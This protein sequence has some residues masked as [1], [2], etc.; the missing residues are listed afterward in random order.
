MKGFYYTIVFL[1]NFLLNAYTYIII[2]RAIVSWL[3]PNPY[4]PIIRLLYRVTEPVLG[5]VRRLLPDLGGLDLSP[6][7]V[8]LAIMLIKQLL[9]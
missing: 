6:V 2:A 4:N 9:I 8:I 1:L 7:L 5:R 3:N